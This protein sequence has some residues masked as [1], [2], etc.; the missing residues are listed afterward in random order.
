MTELA[1]AL[2]EETLKILNDKPELAGDSMVWLT[3]V[4]RE[5]LAGRYVSVTWDMEEFLGR[6]Q[7]IVEG[8]LLKIRLDVGV[9]RG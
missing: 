4:R 5:W 6:K 2:P 8:D 3:A 9:D 1:S 7:N